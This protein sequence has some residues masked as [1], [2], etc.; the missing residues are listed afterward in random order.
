[1][2]CVSIYTLSCQDGWSRGGVEMGGEFSVVE[3]GEVVD[4]ETLEG[5]E[6]V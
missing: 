5:E 2:R 1:M 6:V 3:E 4:R